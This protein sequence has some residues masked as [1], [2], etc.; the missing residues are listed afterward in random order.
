MFSRNTPW[1]DAQW[2]QGG[3]CLL[4]LPTGLAPDALQLHFMAEV[5][6]PLTSGPAYRWSSHWLMT[7]SSGP[8]PIKYSPASWTIL[9]KTWPMKHTQ[10]KTLGLLNMKQA[11][12]GV[13]KQADRFS[14]TWQQGKPAS[15]LK[16]VVWAETGAWVDMDAEVST[17]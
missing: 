5:T 4:P 9:Q 14:G 3:C 6:W 15:S 11:E 16:P 17:L 7:C 10:S 2:S 1:I 8:A 12:I 13:R